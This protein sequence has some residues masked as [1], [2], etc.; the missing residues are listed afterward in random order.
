MPPVDR[1]TTIAELQAELDR[2]R[3]AGRTVGLVPTMG[4]LHDGHLSL[5]RAAAEDCDVVVMSIF[6]NPLQF[7][8]TEDL[9][10]YPRDPDGD[11]AKAASAGVTMLFTPSPTEMYPEGRDAVLTGVAVPELSS[12]MEGVSRR[13]HFGGV[14]TVVAKLF[15]IVGACRAYFGEKDYQQLAIVR[16]MAHDLSFPVEV[17][18]RPIVRE[19]DGLAM[20]SRNVY[21]TAEERQVAPV[22]QRALR[23]GAA[24]VRTGT[25]D[26]DE[27]RTLMRAEIQA[28]PLGELDY[29]E[30]ADPDTLAPLTVADGRSRLFGAVQ[31]GRARLIDNVGVGEVADTGPLPLLEP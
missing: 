16:R 18:G 9:A 26:A 14:C 11:A 21:L 5:A 28:A 30:V 24:A 1:V 29:V 23:L 2:A 15:N 7:A 4:Y 8:P 3:A 13:T 6:V 25:S 19:A 10:T 20:S 17:I 27:V 12:V 31:F 22:L